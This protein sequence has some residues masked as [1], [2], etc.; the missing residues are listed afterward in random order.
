MDLRI[1]QRMCVSPRVQKMCVLDAEAL[2]CLTAQSTQIG[3]LRV[4]C[5]KKP[6]Q[7]ENRSIHNLTVGRNI[8]IY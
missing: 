6:T 1:E 5:V 3:Q 4:G 8:T 2:G 7:G